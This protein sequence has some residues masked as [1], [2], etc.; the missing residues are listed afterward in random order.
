MFYFECGDGPGGRCYDWSGGGISGLC[1]VTNGFVL[2]LFCF[3]P[4][5][6]CWRGQANIINRS[7]RVQLIN[8]SILICTA[9]SLSKVTEN[10]LYIQ[11]K[12]Q[13][14][15]TGIFF[16]TIVM[17]TEFNKQQNVWFSRLLH[18]NN[19]DWYGKKK[20][21]YVKDTQH[22]CCSYQKGKCQWYICFWLTDVSSSN[23][24][25]HQW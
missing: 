9:K 20:V 8:R 1:D 22:V 10:D 24:N 11:K 3:K 23:N 19:W 16:D 5:S 25:F 14:G 18:L 15:F 21:Y 7:P 2:K 13:T 4:Y 12:K 17:N 6:T